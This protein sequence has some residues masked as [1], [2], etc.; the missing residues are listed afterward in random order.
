MRESIL[1]TRHSVRSFQDKPVDEALI[2]E[3]IADA[4]L[5]PSWCNSQPAKAYVVTG[6]LAKKLVKDHHEKN[7]TKAR[8]WGEIMPPQPDTWNPNNLANI[9]KFLTDGDTNEG[10]GDK[11]G[12]IKLNGCNF[13]APVIIYITV[14]KNST[15]YQGYDA[16]AF[17]YGICL[18]AHEHGLGTIPAYEFVRFPEEIREIFDI[19]ENES[20]LMGIGMGYPDDAE[21]ND[22]YKI[23]GRVPTDS[24][25]TIRS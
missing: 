10:L 20:I 1:R 24:I 8:S 12:I 22:F 5:A 21:V 7:V 15:M 14:P 2:R 3:I 17:G 18:S 11:F 9:D 19:P 6:E 23:N 4:Q 25:L 16:G 13:Q